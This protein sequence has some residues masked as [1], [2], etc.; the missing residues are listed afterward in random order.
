MS[1]LRRSA[2]L[3]SIAGTVS[4]AGCGVT[5][6]VDRDASGRPILIRTPQPDA[7]DIRD[8]HAKYGVKTVINLRGEQS[9]HAW[10][11][12]E[13]DAVEEVGA[14]M[15]HID[16]SGSN[17][18]KD[19]EIETFFSVMEDPA[20][21]PVVVHCFGG[22]HRTGAVAALYRMQYQGWC[23]PLAVR[24]M[25]DNYFN[26]TTRDRSRLKE[27]LRTGYERDPARRIE[28]KPG[29]GEAKPTPSEPA[30]EPTSKGDAR[31]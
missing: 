12:E 11:R 31:S 23:G 20:N 19:E 2:I 27:W 13:R 10:Y 7:D 24:D 28:R 8:L 17:P 9:E 6:V 1:I 22:V 21:W 29:A 14:R 3:L 4:L 30:A 26:W 15:V 18:L 25:E 16:I 5:E